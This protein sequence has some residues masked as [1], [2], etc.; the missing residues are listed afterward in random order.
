MNAQISFYDTSFEYQQETK[1]PIRFSPETELEKLLTSLDE[2]VSQMEAKTEAERSYYESISEA[3]RRTKGMDKISI[4]TFNALVKHFVKH[5]LFRNAMYLIL[6]ANYGMRFSDVA[7]LRFCHIFNPDGTIKEAF[8]LPNG[9][10]KTG[11]QNIYYNN[12]ATKYIIKMYLN[13]RRNATM[14]DFLFVSTSNNKG[15]YLTLEQT[16]AREMFGNDI[17]RLRKKLSKGNRTAEEK[18]RIR[19]KIEEL[20]QKMSEYRS[21]SKDKNR[22]IQQPISHETANTI[23][24]KMGL[25]DIGIKALNCLKDDLPNSDVKLGTHS[26]RKAFGDYFYTRAFELKCKGVVELQMLDTTLLKLLQ[27][28]YMHSDSSV[29]RCYNDL[30]EQAFRAICTRLDLGFEALLNATGISD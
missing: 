1:Q 16:E 13:T 6:Q 8:T 25:K 29:T 18:D 5:K 17:E 11:K 3:Q 10:L 12:S 15:E 23:I 14:Y 27:D 28:K 7:R 4:E 24:L 26:F 19:A 9:E 21:E 30:E 22:L 2:P 20:E